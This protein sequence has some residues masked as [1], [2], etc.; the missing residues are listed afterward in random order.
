MKELKDYIKIYDGAIAPELCTKI[1]TAFDSD[2]EYYLDSYTGSLATPSPDTR[3]GFSNHRNAIELNC[4]KRAA[5]APKWNGIMRVMTHHA[6][7]M[8][9]RYRKDL[10]AD[11]FP[12]NQLFEEVTLEQF[13][14]HRYDKN[15]HYYKQ[16]IDSIESTSCKRMLVLLYYL[17]T[18][19]E[20]GETSFDTIEYEA[21]N[22]HWE[23]MKVKPVE[24]RLCIAPTWFGYPHSAEMPISNT[25]YMIKTYIHYPER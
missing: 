7:H 17:N 13:R 21:S 3:T 10:E 11:G 1:I 6:A 4:T 24:G 9:K 25:K 14:M 12:K 15:E 20:G 23:K 22:L 5:E 2:D 8:Y 16:H 19:K 18:V